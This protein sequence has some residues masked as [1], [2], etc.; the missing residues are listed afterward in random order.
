MAKSKA[1]KYP[2][3]MVTWVD[4]YSADAWEPITNMVP[5]VKLCHTVGFLLARNNKAVVVA[6][7]VSDDG[8]SCCVM[9]IPPGMVRKFNYL[10]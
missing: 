10:K 6:S 9:F 7:T 1:H 5:E 4:A 2:L 3:V 8:D